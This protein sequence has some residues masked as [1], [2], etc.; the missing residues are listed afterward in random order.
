MDLNIDA[1]ILNQMIYDVIVIGAG[2][3]GL[4][5]AIYAVRRNLKTLVINKGVVGGQLLLA[6]EVGNYPGFETISG[7]EL[8]K[9]MHEHAKKNQVEIVQDEVIKIEVDN[10]KIKN[11]K[12]IEN[13]YKSKA[14][15]IATGCTHRKLGV[16]G[17]KE[18]TG[19]GVS[20]CATCDAPFFKG[21][22][23]AVVGGGNTAVSDALYLSDIAKKV[24]LIH[25]RDE[26]RAEE[27]EQKKLKEKKVEF[28]LKSVIVKIAGDKMVNGI[29][30][31][32]LDTNETKE[33]E[34]S[35]VFISVGNKP[36]P[37]FCEE[38]GVKKT[39][40]GYLE[41]NQKQETNIEGIFAAG[42]VT[43]GVLQIATAVGGGCVASLSAYE[44]VKRPYWS[45]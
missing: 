28:M 20:Y 45:K 24:Y 39:D 35:G 26:L 13:E 36:S 15:I 18:F 9:R 37:E 6:K 38:L 4:C 31:R 23:V 43:G 3:A 7:P 44:Y 21:R 32:N 42:D 40:K 1:D 29:L 19:K 2:P 34:V 17:E 25:R 22:A 8:A 33:L 11:V 14:V 27:V 12:T 5:A 10:N 30:V 16:E 41:V